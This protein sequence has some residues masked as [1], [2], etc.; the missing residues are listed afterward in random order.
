MQLYQ[1]QTLAAVVELGSLTQASARLNV[2]QPAASAQ[3]KA[4]EKECGIAL[5]ER[6]HNGLTLT[7]AGAALLPEIKNCWRRR[8]VWHCTRKDCAAAYRAPSRSP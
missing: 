5:F 3:I 7:R 4:L 1:L 2:S 8:R 6:K